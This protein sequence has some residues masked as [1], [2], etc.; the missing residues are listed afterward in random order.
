[1]ICRRSLRRCQGAL[2][3]APKPKSWSTPSAIRWPCCGGI[4]DVETAPNRLAE[5][6]RRAEDPNLWSNAQVAQKVMRQRQALENS[7]NGLKTLERD[8]DDA[9]TL[10][11]LGESEGDAA[12]VTEGE[13]ALRKLAGEARRQEVEALLS[14]EA[15]GN[16]T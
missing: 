10:I 4:F 9:L 15:D 16:D 7:I 1:L 11:E 2:P 6:N 8:F 5:L 13:A 12:T 3:C 14:G